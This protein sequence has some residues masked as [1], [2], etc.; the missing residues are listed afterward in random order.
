MT[1]RADAINLYEVR[2][3]AL[4]TAAALQ[5]NVSDNDRATLIADAEAIYQ[6]LIT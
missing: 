4:D 5:C 1:T 2:K 6:W 3:Y